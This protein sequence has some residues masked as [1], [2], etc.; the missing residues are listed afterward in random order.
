METAITRWLHSILDTFHNRLMVS[1]SLGSA[2]QGLS[3]RFL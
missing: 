3:S 1:K 2:Q